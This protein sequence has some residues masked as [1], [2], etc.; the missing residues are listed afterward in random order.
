[1]APLN[2]R[3]SHALD[4]FMALNYEVQA[5]LKGHH[6]AL[7][8]AGWHPAEAWA[9]CQQVEARILGPAM[10]VAREELAI[11]DRVAAAVEEEIRRRAEEK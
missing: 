6:D 5:R 3:T 9:L 8:K 4:Q 11:G 2:P 7:V 1:M 10:E